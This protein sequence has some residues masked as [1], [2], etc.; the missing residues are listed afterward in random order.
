M[1]ALAGCFGSHRLDWADDAGEFDSEGSGG[2]GGSSN[3]SGLSTVT[4]HSGASS[5]DDSTGGGG[6]GAGTTGGSSESGSGD[7]DMP[8]E[9][10]T[11]TVNGVEGQVKILN[12]GPAVVKAIAVDDL[13]VE[14]VD[15][16]L[17]GATL[18]SDTEPPFEWTFG[19]TTDAMNGEHTLSAIAYDKL[20]Q[21]G[22]SGPVLIDIELPLGGSQIWQA[23]GNDKF[24]SQAHG[25]AVDGLGDVIVVGYESVSNKPGQTR[26]AIRKY[27]GSDGELLW[28]R[29]VPT[30][31]EDPAPV[32]FNI[33]RGVA[34][35]SHDN[36]FVVGELSAG[37][38]APRFWLGK[39]TS[40]GLRIGE[41]TSALPDSYGRGVA[42]DGDD[43]VFGV[44][45]AIKV[46]LSWTGL[47]A[48]YDSN[49]KPLWNKDFGEVSI[50]SSRFLGATIDG[51]GDVVLAGDVN[52]AADE[53]RGLVAKYAPTGQLSW[54]RPTNVMGK[55]NDSLYSV[56]I[57]DGDEIIALGRRR[58]SIDLEDRLW[59]LR[60]DPSGNE[61][62]SE[63]DQ[64]GFCGDQDGC[65]IAIDPS[66]HLLVAGATLNQV[67]DYDFMVKKLDAGWDSALWTAS[68]DGYDSEQDR[69]LAVAVD[70]SGFV[71]GVG[72]E[73]KLGTHE[74]WVAKFNP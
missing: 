48:A 10:V 7:A 33:A 20:E 25:V 37:G 24:D 8:P 50:K 44:G 61:T 49:L 5:G 14:R 32:G 4:G 34:I 54:W 31:L 17:D 53:K 43:R 35:D 59:L 74:W 29:E 57:A 68:L 72:F 66:G 65:G 51:V 42:I 47:I 1:L 41:Q 64:I 56:Q 39:Y 3:A 18:G 2:Q 6:T 11:L 26:M 27:R 13:G 9:I 73:S 45:Y 71:Y 70:A 36:V 28:A 69:S 58:S 12:A 15:F 46:D 22:E 40:G 60:V 19:V 38:E 62:D 55:P 30:S 63:V 52:G 21:S 67:T 23:T 16:I